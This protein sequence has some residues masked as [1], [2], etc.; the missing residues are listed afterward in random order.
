MV[1]P[2]TIACPGS[3]PEQ[4][5]GHTTEALRKLC[6]ISGTLRPM[7]QARRKPVHIHCHCQPI[8][9][10]LRVFRSFVL[11]K[12]YELLRHKPVTDN[13]EEKRKG[14]TQQPQ[15][16]LGSLS[17]EHGQSHWGKRVAIFCLLLLFSDSVLA[18]A[19]SWLKCNNKVLICRVHTSMSPPL[20]STTTAHEGLSP[21][22]YIPENGYDFLLS[23]LAGCL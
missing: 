2:D 21:V 12:V 15:I 8:V 20:R 22:G 7:R 14:E 10:Q 19:L 1:P 5:T 9:V 17:R 23:M 18:S 11:A 3:A 13:E 6:L 4:P 16:S